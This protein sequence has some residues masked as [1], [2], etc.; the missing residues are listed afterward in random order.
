MQMQMRSATLIVTMAGSL[1]LQGCTRDSAGDAARAMAQGDAFAKAGKDGQAAIEYRRAIQK[2]PRLTEAHAKLADVA[3]R[4]HDART[5]TTEIIAVANLEPANA[6]AQ[7][8][9]M[10]AYRVAG[11]TDDA[12]AML[13]RALTA[14]PSDP[15]VHAAAAEYYM[16]VRRPAEAE[17]HL[18]ALA[19]SPSADPFALGDFYSLEQRW[20]EA[21]AEFRR[22]ERVRPD[23]AAEARL[24]LATL[25]YSTNRSSEA[26]EVVASIVTAN[27][28]SV[29]AWLLRARARLRE[30]KPDEA[31]RAFASALAID[32]DSVDALAGLTAIDLDAKRDNEAIA[33]LERA[34]A[35]TPQSVPVLTLMAQALARTGATSRAAQ[36]LTQIIA[37]QPSVLDAYLL[38]GRLYLQQGHLEEARHSYENMAAQGEGALAARTMIG[39]ILEAE[40][41]QAEARAAY[42]QVLQTHPDAAVAANNLAW[43]DLQAGRLD[44]ALRCALIASDGLRRL[45]QVQDTLGWVYYQKGDVL[46]ALTHLTE[47]VDAQPGNPLFRAHLGLAYAKDGSVDRA[48]EELARALSTADDFRG[49]AEAEAGLREL[50]PSKS[51]AAAR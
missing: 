13:Q 12:A 29:A 47:A 35:R 22:L 49:R 4:L 20:R 51:T 19:A 30:R 33:R 43:M 11:R 15:V 24:R 32:A 46:N 48:R 39:M 40:G 1:V 50:P 28:R 9:A 16:Q 31:K 25:L 45:P 3:A 5:A 34:L 8:R 26:D 37:I 7:L 23:R 42:E 38:L 27:P 10:S 18:A 21:E 17:P 6:T 36:T 44:E 14:S 41:K 2:A